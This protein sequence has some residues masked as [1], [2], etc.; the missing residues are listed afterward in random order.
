MIFSLMIPM[1]IG[2][3]IGA[4]VITNSGLTYEDLGVIKQ[5]PTPAIFIASAVVVILTL[6]PVW[7]AIKQE[8]KTL[9]EHS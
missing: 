5:V 1:I 7:F 2:P 6:I 9:K 8:K 3:F 4:R